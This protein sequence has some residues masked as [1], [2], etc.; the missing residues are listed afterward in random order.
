[1]TSIVSHIWK[2]VKSRTITIDGFIPVPRGTSVGPPV[3]ASWPA[4]DPADILDYQLNIGPAFSG[5]DGDYITGVDVDISP[6]Q[7]GDLSLDNVSADGP[8]VILWLSAGFPGVN[9]T[10]TI[11]A[12]LSSGRIIQRS[13]L[14]PVVLLSSV[15]IPVNA[16]LTTTRDP[17]T[18]ESGVPIY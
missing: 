15:A 18:D 13:I 5:N 16:L 6:G 8:N 14:L 7:P 3:P 10:I 9:Y 12:S 4:K 1:M 11:K 17:L 2:P